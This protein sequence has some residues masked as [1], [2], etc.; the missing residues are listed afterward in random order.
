[1]K[2]LCYTLALGL[3]VGGA[4]HALPLQKELVPGDAK[5][6]VHLD[7]DAFRDSRLGGMTLNEMLAAPLAQLKAQFKID[8]QLVLQKLH[9]IT[10]FGNDFEAGPKADGVLLLSG[11]EELLKIV[12]GLLAAQILQD[13]GATIKKVQQ[14]PFPLYSVNEEVFVSPRLGGQVVVSKSRK[15]IESLRKLLEGQGK[16]GRRSEPFSGYAKVPNTFFFLAVAEGFNDNAA[17]PAQA[18]I[19]KMAEGARIVVGEKADLVFLNLALKAK[20]PEVIQQ[21]RQ[22]IEGMT[23]LLALGQ[24]ENKELLELV[25]ATKVSSTDKMVTVNIEYPLEKV[26]GRLNGM[27]RRLHK[28]L[29]D[30]AH[31]KP[32]KT[33][34]EDP[35]PPD[36]PA[37]K[38]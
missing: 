8:G 32:V 19:L 38:N 29:R 14:E 35:A 6:L 34:A 9:S 4:A 36:S 2:L 20:D 37:K 16:G 28:N 15:N 3:T 26:F 24:S 1:M 27:S 13:Q 31:A 18:K 17:L 30:P 11:D 33:E 22:V 21:I 10:A 7:V 5:W 25:Q 23:A 12:E